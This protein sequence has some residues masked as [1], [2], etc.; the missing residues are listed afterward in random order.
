MVAA[1]QIGSKQ[2]SS[3]LLLPFLNPLAFSFSKVFAVEIKQQV[4]FYGMVHPKPAS[5]AELDSF[6]LI[7][8]QFIYLFYQWLGL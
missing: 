7:V 4:E 2:Q 3:F 1:K 8:L 6:A 5:Q